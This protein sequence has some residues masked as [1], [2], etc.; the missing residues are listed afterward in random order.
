VLKGLVDK[1]VSS[2]RAPLQGS[3]PG[4]DLTRRPVGGTDALH[5]LLMR[6]DLGEWWSTSNN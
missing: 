2:S 3:L 6:L 4:G 5:H 1:N